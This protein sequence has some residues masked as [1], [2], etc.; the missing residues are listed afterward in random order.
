MARQGLKLERFYGSERFAVMV[1]GTLLGSQGIFLALA[2]LCATVLGW[3]SQMMTCTVGFSGVLF[4]LK[5][6]LN[7]TVPEHMQSIYGIPVHSKYAAW[8]ELVLIQMI[9]PNASWLGHLSGILA[10]LAWVYAPRLIRRIRHRLGHDVGWDHGAGFAGHRPADEPVRR[11]AG[12]G[13]AGGGNVGGGGG[14]GGGGHGGGGGGGGYGGGGGASGS[15]GGGGSGS[16]TSGKAQTYGAGTWG[17][18]E[19]TPASNASH[20]AAGVDERAGSTRSHVA[21]GGEEPPSHSEVAAPTTANAE[22]VRAARLRFFESTKR[23]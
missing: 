20:G 22:D 13:D 4:A 6:I 18:S 12:G 14:G 2:S 9:V 15:A 8:L 16:G 3:R 17:G 7:F 1:A 10:G 11:G 5:V 23:R 19:A 21:P